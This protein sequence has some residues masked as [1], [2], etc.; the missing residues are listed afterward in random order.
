MRLWQPRRNR[1]A[2]LVIDKGES[3]EPPRVALPGAVA[4]LAI[5]GGKAELTDLKGAPLHC[6]GNTRLH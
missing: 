5:M 3:G 2:D 4:F 1:L 6:Q